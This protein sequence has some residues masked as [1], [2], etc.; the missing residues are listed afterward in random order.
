MFLFEGGNEFKFQDGTNAT[1]QNASTEEADAAL[2]VLG[3]EIGIDLLAKDKEDKWK[4]KAG[5]VIY[6]GA[7]TGDADVIL[8]PADFIQIPDNTPPKDVQNTFRGWLAQKL[9]AAG[10]Q[11]LPKK[12]F[13]EQPGKY[14]KIA[15][16][17]LTAC[18]QMPNNKEF[19]QVDLDIAEPKEGAFSVWS[20][21]GEP[22]KPGTPKDAKAKGAFRHILKTEIARIVTKGPAG[23]DYPQGLSWSYKNG[24]IDRATNQQI[25]N[26]KNPD[27]IAKVLFNGRASDLDNI[28]AIL[29][30]FKSSHPAQYRDVVNKV[31]AGLE[32]YKTQYRLNE[33]SAM[34]LGSPEWFRH[35]MTKFS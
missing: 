13:I 31:N 30:K 4:H 8:D 27:M 3:S 28:E 6:P 26:G 14:Y 29:A 16:D 21:R 34:S 9:Q 1:K 25:Q 35:M 33:Y 18:V 17:G 12:A 23:E 11:E 24:L 20:K 10:Y 22:N 32:K 5:S 15:G 19:L 2:S 7:E